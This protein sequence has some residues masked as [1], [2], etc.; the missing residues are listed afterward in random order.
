MMTWYIVKRGSKTKKVLSSNPLSACK[1]AF[2][3]SG[4]WWHWDACS[5]N[6][7]AKVYLNGKVVLHCSLHDNG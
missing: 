3:L 5:N 6:G 2:R 4:G 1:K 7:E